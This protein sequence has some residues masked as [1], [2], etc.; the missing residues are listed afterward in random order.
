[1]SQQMGSTATRTRDA[2]AGEGAVDDHRHGT[3]RTERAKRWAAPDEDDVRVR[4]RSS[5]RQIRDQRIAELVRQRQPRLTA[6][7]ARYVN[8][9]AF[10]I[11]V[12]KPQ[13]YDVTRAQSQTPEQ[14][15]NGVVSLTDGRRAIAG[16]EDPFDFVLGQVARQGREASMHQNRNRS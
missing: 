9:R 1:M 15:Q 12:A 14:K 2:G 3:M 13:L 10:P 11:D 16:G 4:Q 8:P 5:A 6:A 7:L